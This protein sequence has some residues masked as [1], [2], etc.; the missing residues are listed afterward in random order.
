MRTYLSTRPYRE[1]L[2]IASFTLACLLLIVLTGCD[3]RTE[4]AAASAAL[5]PRPEAV[6]Q[7]ARDIKAGQHAAAEQALLAFLKENQGNYYAPE[8]EYLLG[9]A[10][11]AQG[12][13]EDGKSHLETAID[14]ANSRTLK[15][16]AMLGRAD[17]NMA[18][19]KYSLASRQY[20]W[21][22]TMYRDV[23]AIPQDEVLFKLGMATKAAGCPETADYWFNQVIELYATG[24]YAAQA[25]TQNSKY[26]PPD[27]DA[28]PLVFSL[29]V[30]VFANEDKANAE[31]EA[32]RAKGYRN[33]EVVATT[34]NS[35]P[36]FEV[37]MGRFQNRNE[38]VRAQTD[39]ELAGLNT[40]I[41]PG[42]IE[43]LK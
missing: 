19:R 32:L 25:K 12:H 37:R 15:A 16:L 26:N 22:E 36:V 6:A 24:P 5:P 7:A 35:N 43:P 30:S 4:D 9:Q 28:Q 2:W 21:L 39:A 20:H 23:K 41:R 11:A 1:W 34:R 8:A 42:A 3:G 31:A 14:N 18:L 38:A 17:C 29:E 33:I 13:Y 10:I 40:T 27:P